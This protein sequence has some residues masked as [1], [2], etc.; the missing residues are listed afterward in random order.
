MSEARLIEG[1]AKLQ[2][3][4]V[5]QSYALTDDDPDGKAEAEAAVA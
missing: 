5:E 4:A 1:L 2:A 3:F